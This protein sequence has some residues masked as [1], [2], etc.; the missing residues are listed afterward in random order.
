MAGLISIVRAFFGNR[1]RMLEKLG[2][3][4]PRVARAQF[5]RVSVVLVN[6][7]D[8]VQDVLIDRAEDQ[9]HDVG[10]ERDAHRPVEQTHTRC[11][12]SARRLPLARRAADRCKAA[13]K[14]S[15][16]RLPVS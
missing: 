7:P 4:T 15:P 9:Q 2:A 13:R 6:A 3:Q 14:P 12:G 10:G 11:A 8:L 1:L 16:A 5:G